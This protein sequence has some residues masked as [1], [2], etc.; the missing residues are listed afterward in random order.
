MPVKSMSSPA[1]IIRTP[2][3]AK[4]EHKWIWVDDDVLIF[5]AVPPHLRVQL[6]K[7]SVVVLLKI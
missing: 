6:V 7:F 3:D 2:F 4:S 5:A 1:T